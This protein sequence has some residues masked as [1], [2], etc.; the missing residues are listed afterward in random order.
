VKARG[1]C[2]AL[3]KSRTEDPMQA[4]HAL[5]AFGCLVGKDLISELRL[6]RSWPAM[7]LLGLVLVMLLEMQVDLAS[8]EKQQIVSGLLW[9]DIFFAGTL[10]VDRSLAG[11]REEGCWKSLLLYPVSP[12]IVF[13]AKVAVTA[14]ALLVLE[15]VLVPAFIVF[16][17]LPL[18]RHPLGFATVAVL[19]N[20][21]YGSVGVVTSAL[22]AQLSHRNSLLPLVL[23]PL[24]TPVILS[25]AGA[26]RLV[27][28]STLDEQ[29]WRWVQL[30]GC[31][32]VVFTA[33]GAIVFEF[34]IED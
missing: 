25:A 23:L 12:T 14:I 13:F 33:L 2:G 16:S 5:K 7:L 28:S 15:C 32:A 17:N 19:A 31:F 3:K 22:T 20:L 8:Y 29:W 10:M 9:L 6:G 11:E 26:T 24:M 4:G 34:A 21:G 27:V 30:L 1:W 18:L